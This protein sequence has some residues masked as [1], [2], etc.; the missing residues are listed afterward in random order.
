MRVIHRICTAFSKPKN[1]LFILCKKT[2]NSV[3]IVLKKLQAEPT[4]NFVVIIVEVATIIFYMA[5]EVIICEESMG[6]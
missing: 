6:Y 3:C 5:I 2:L 4:R 1:Q